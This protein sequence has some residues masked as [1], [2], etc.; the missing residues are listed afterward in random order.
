[1]PA[2][3]V[4]FPVDNGDMT[5]ITLA[6]GRTIL[7]DINIRQDADNPLTS[8]YDVASDLRGRLKRDMNNRPFV[9]VFLLSHPDKDHCTGLQKHFHLGALANYCDDNKIDNEKRI[10]IRELWSSPMVFR[11]ASKNHTLCEDACAFNTE[12]RRRVKINKENNFFNIPQGDQILIMGEDE[13]GKTDDLNPILIKSGTTFRINNQ[14]YDSNLECFLI[15]PMTKQ[16]EELECTLSK[17]HSSVIINFSIASNNHSD[18]CRFLSGGDAEVE[19]WEMI[20]D[21]YRSTPEI[22]AYNILQT[23]HH[24]SWRT[25]SYDSWSEKGES[26]KESADAVNALS[27]ARKGAAIVASSKLIQDEDSDPPCI[28]AKRTYTRIVQQ[29]SVSGKFYCT[30]EYPKSTNV[31]P[32]IFEIDNVGVR[33]ANKAVIGAASIAASPNL[34]AG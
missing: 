13:N 29:L 19:I 31:K 18:K 27:Q 33:V 25:L 10:V 11:R 28:R 26:A 7:V 32:L 5:L 34:R 14:E 15:A 23:P 21:K 6:D 9:D 22:L 8:T 12:A 3:I 30:G 20:W 2:S 1:M 16:S 4:F 17:N 24:C